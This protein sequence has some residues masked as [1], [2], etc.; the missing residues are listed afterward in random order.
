M[1]TEGLFAF[2]M[3]ALSACS[4]ASGGGG[5]AGQAVQLLQPG[6]LLR[7]GSSA[8][9]GDG[10][11]LLAALNVLGGGLAHGSGHAPHAQHVVPDLE[12]L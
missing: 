5:D 10:Q 8:G 1:R 3:M 2:V 12:R 9:Q 6:S 11:G 7:G 4:A